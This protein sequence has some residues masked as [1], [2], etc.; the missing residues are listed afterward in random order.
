M[1]ADHSRR[2]LRPARILVLSFLTAIGLGTV[3]LL[4]PVAVAPGRSTDPVT[5]LF[6]ATSAVCVTGLVVVETGRHWSPFGQ[7]VIALLIQVGGIGI[8]TTGTVFALVT[9][10]R[11]G[12][13][14]R[15]VIHE[16]F[17]KDGYAG[18]VRLVRVIVTTTLVLEA[19]GAVYLAARFARDMP[20]G[21]AAY[22]GVFHAVSAF[23]NAGFDLF[24][25]SLARYVAD[26]V[27]NLGF[28]SLIITGGLGFPVLVDV[29]GNIR[30]RGRYLSLHTRIVLATTAV[31]L[32]AGAASILV[33]EWNNPATLAPLGWKGRL[34]ASLFHSVTPRTA[35]F[36]TLPTGQLFPATLLLSMVLMF[37]G[38]SPGGTGGGIKTTT[39]VVLFTEVKSVLAGRADMELFGR[40]IGRE[41]AG[42]SLA[43][44][45][46]S[47]VLVVATT[48]FLLTTEAFGFLPVLFESV[49]AFGTVGLSMGITPE[50]SVAGRLMVVLTMFTGRVGTLTV[51]L[52][53][54]TRDRV[55]ASYRR[56]E[57]KIMVG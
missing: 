13:R 56:P 31:L 22:F 36:N 19:I 23:C 27:V 49:S 11:I 51:F 57:E 35:G 33:L 14:E 32:V 52:A 12:L 1:L 39:A 44:A 38:A 29:T 18:M 40:R 9:G 20:P 24:G 34:L 3:L 48:A 6:T 45:F 17:G 41:V 55:P 37:I 30:R 7:A 4:L 54:A 5:A 43:I 46:L 8:M 10:R 53:V 47:L 16:T 21:R 50:L 26:P 2:A 42:K 25:D 15:L 28:M